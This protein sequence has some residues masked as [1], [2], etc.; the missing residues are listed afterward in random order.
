MSYFFFFFVIALV[1]YFRGIECVHDNKKLCKRSWTQW[2][3]CSLTCGHGTKTRLGKRSRKNKLEKPRYHKIKEISIEDPFCEEE[4]IEIEVCYS[5]CPCNKEWTTWSS[6]SHS[7]GF[8]GIQ[9]RF[10]MKIDST[11]DCFVRSNKTNWRL[12]NRVPCSCE[13]S[14]SEWSPCNATC[15]NDG[16]QTRNHTIITPADFGGSCDKKLHKECSLEPCSES[17]ILIILITAA[18]VIIALSVSISIYLYKRSKEASTESGQRDK[19]DGYY[20]CYHDE[21]KNKAKKDTETDY[22][23]YERYNVEDTNIEDYY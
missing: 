21:Y 17:W 5:P 8:E 9:S 18:F 11:V 10:E 19:N 23:Y 3:S 16:R 12:C 1:N 4:K 20:Q 14:Y 22:N 6:C 7:C 15:G 2:T 13:V